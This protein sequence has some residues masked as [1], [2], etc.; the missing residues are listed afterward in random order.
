MGHGLK[1]PSD[2]ADW[3]RWQQRR[4]LVRH[5]RHNV[6]SSQEPEDLT[7]TVVRGG[8]DADVVVVVDA[9]HASMA[10]AVVAPLRA[11]PAERVITVLGPG[12]KLDVAGARTSVVASRLGPELASGRVLLGCGHFTSAGEA[13]WRWAGQAGVPTHVAQHG[14][15]TPFVPPLPDNTH[16]LS[17]SEADGSFWRSGRADV[18]STAVGSQL[19]WQAERGF[20]ARFARTST[21]G[22]VIQP[23]TYLGQG[24]GA[25]IP[26]PL[27][28]EAALRFCRAH[29]ATYRPHPSEKDRLSRLAHSGYQRA[30]IT[31]DRSGAPLATWDGPV[32]SIFSTGVLEMAARGVDAWVD[33]PRPPAWLGEFWERYGMRRFGGP[34]T[35]AP[36]RPAEE[37]ARRIAEILMEAAR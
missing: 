34:P 5:L 2:L 14:A 27:L 31:I 10:S 7:L 12:V 22:S 21:S 6:L 17:W 11:L 15:L 35:P 16:L 9:T 25:E 19:L 1:F 36:A 29:D 37:P 26:R 4:H 32:V 20:A 24:H 23:L 28:I 8:P 3:R 13:A 18:T 30:G 33:F